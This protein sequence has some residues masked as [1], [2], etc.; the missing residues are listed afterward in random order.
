MSERPPATKAPGPA[1]YANSELASFSNIF[2]KLTSLPRCKMAPHC[3]WVR[4][5]ECEK[6]RAVISARSG[7]LS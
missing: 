6:T 4:I 5:G 3:L 7:V 1:N 2:A